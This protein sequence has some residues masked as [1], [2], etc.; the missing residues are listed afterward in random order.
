MLWNQQKTSLPPI[1]NDIN[2]SSERVFALT[3]ANMGGKSTVMK[4]TALLCV[5]AQ[6]E[7]VIYVQCT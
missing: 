4:Q 2:I 6:G 1:A 7:E 3:G 5:L